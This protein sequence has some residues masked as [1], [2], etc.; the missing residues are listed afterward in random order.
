MRHP[1]A[2]ARTFFPCVKRPGDH[3]PLKNVIDIMPMETDTLEFAATESGD[4]FFHCHILY[5]MMSGMGRI[6]SYENSPPNRNC[7]G[8]NRRFESYITTTVNF[9]QWQT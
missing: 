9:T 1:Y 7:P 8:L 3:S 4:W 6:F 2:F 5:H